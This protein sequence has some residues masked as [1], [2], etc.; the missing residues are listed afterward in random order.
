MTMRIAFFVIRLVAD[1]LDHGQLLLAHLLGD[2]LD[3][4]VAGHLVRQLGDDD[5]AVVLVSL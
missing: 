2:L 5:V 4:L 3:D 1:V